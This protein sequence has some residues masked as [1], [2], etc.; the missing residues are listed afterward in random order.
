MTNRI[1]DKMSKLKK[2]E[3]MDIDS[4][5][6]YFLE[7]AHNELLK[8]KNI[9]Y[10]YPE[11]RREAYL[12]YLVDYYRNRNKKI[13]NIRTVPWYGM[14]Y[15]MVTNPEDFDYLILDTA[16]QERIELER[17]LAIDLHWKYSKKIISMQVEAMHDDCPEVSV[18]YDSFLEGNVSLWDWKK[19]KYEQSKVSGTGA[20]WY[21]DQMLAGKLFLHQYQYETIGYFEALW[22]INLLITDIRKGFYPDHG[23]NVEVRVFNTRFMARILEENYYPDKDQVRSYEKY[24]LVV[25]KDGKFDVGSIFWNYVAK[26]HDIVNPDYMVDGVIRRME[27]GGFLNE[28]RIYGLNFR[29]G[30]IHVRF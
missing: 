10:V 23:E 26:N 3:Q 27:Q 25:D 19:W 22:K 30:E 12:Q 21:W 28:K 11:Y 18:F 17:Y 1:L 20:D 7:R 29:Y 13:G 4:R 2:P 5:F 6:T 9:L 24:N 15:V 8:G 16:T 14:G